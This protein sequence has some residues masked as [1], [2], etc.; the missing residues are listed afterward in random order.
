MPKKI[1]LRADG[2][3][4]TGLG[5]L[6][7]LIALTDIYR[8]H[9]D[10][11]F[12]TKH[13][14]SRDIFTNNYP[15]E[16]IPDELSIDE[17]PQWIFHKYSPIDY[18]IILDGYSFDNDYQKKLKHLGYSIVYID[19]MNKGPFY[20]DAV[21]NHAPGLRVEDFRSYGQTQFYLGSK[22][23]ILRPEFLEAAKVKRSINHID[24]LFI[25]FGGA[26][27]YNLTKKVLE[28]VLDINQ[29]STINI[30]VGNAYSDEL[31]LSLENHQEKKINIYKNVNSK[32]LIAIMLQ[33]N[34]A[35]SPASTISLEIC[36]IKMPLLAGYFVDNQKNIYNGLKANNAIYLG[37]DFRKNKT[38]DFKRKIELILRAENYQ[39]IM[40][41]QANLLDEKI[42][43][44][45]LDIVKFLK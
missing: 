30:V 29:I 26:D 27:N 23:A 19:D 14:T 34:M 38:T 1:L 39:I 44:R 7:R 25:C 17:E 22:Y 10:C 12:L 35:I 45:L 5:H 41:N 13:S 37:E 42:A 16:F 31:L 9:F 36:C 20:A 8:D 28:A 32:N 11:V 6:Y 43:N 3:K 33:S 2:N 15:L 40:E 4:K 21:I 24:T 18:I